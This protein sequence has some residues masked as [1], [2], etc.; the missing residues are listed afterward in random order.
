MPERPRSGPL[1]DVVVVDA[2]EGVAGGFAGRLL[3]DLGA[4]VVKVEPPGGERLRA[5]GPFPGDVPDRERGGLHLGLNAGKESIAL[6]LDR[7]TCSS[8]TPGPDGWQRAG[9]G[10]APC[11]AAI[12]PLSTRRTPRLASMGRTPIG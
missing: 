8:R 1:S 7:P 10:S 12:P 4:R 6:D 9:W 3:A 2:S 11:T 5:L